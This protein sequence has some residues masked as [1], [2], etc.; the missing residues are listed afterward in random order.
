MFRLHK[1]YILPSK[2]YNLD[3]GKQI[4]YSSVNHAKIEFVKSYMYC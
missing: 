3:T 1:Q 2:Q 4:W